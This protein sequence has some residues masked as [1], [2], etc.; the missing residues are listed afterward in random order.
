MKIVTIHKEDKMTEQT[1][2]RV[3]FFRKRLDSLFKTERII[4]Y[5]EDPKNRQVFL[6]IEVVKSF[7]AG[8][9][10]KLCQLFGTRFITLKTKGTSV[11]IVI[12][13]IKFPKVG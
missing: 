8:T 2:D 5:Q 11:Q 12:D 3:F 10:R 13:Q 6:T 1:T 4:E 9:R 7:K